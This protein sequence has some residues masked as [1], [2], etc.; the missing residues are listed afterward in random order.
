MIS[1]FFFQNYPS[2]WENMQGAIQSKIGLELIIVENMPQSTN[3]Y[4]PS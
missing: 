1:G 2:D 4:S 3:Y